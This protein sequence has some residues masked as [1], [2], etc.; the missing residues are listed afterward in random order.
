MKPFWF[1]FNITDWLASKSVRMMSLAERG[2]YIGLL[3]TAWGEDVPGT[4]P[5][6]EDEVRRMAEMSPE[7]WA[8]SGPRLLKKFPVS[9]CGTY[10]YNPRLFLEG[11]EQKRKSE[12]AAEA[13][14]RSAEAKKQRKGN[15]TS[16]DVA[17]K[18][19]GVEKTAT[20]RQLVTDTITSSS[21]EDERTAGAQA[22]S[23]SLLSAGPVAEK[24]GGARPGGKPREFLADEAPTFLTVNFSKFVDK[25]GYGQVDKA[26]YL[27]R[28]QRKAEKLLA[29]TDEGWENY[30]LEWLDRDKR[31]GQLV[32]PALAGPAHT[33]P[34][35]NSRFGP[36]PR[37]ATTGYNLA[38]KLEEQRNNQYL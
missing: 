38:A 14:R 7:Q 25:A 1:A 22:D 16:T 13:G 11:Q 35:D 3:A 19:T 15:G 34:V 27:L 23:A 10:R 9:E 29:R 6:D 33:L 37:P 21:N 5:V 30:I 4:L 20:E 17:K 31:G 8:L 32:L 2:A 24:A 36:A 18:S 26:H 12:L 28:I